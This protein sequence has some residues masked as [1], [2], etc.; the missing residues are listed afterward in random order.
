MR[1]IQTINHMLVVIAL[2]MAAVL[3]AAVAY[4]PARAQTTEESPTA[5]LLDNVAL[6][7]GRICASE[8]GLSRITPGCAAIYEVYHN[9]SQ[10]RQIP[11]LRQARE[12][13]RQSFNRLRTDARRW[14]AFLDPTGAEPQGWPQ[15]AWRRVMVPQEDGTRR[16]MMQQ[17]R[18]AAWSDETRRD[19]FRRRW[20]RL[21]EHSQQIARGEVRHEC[22]LNGH[23]QSPHRW[24]C[25]PDNF[26]EGSCRDHERAERAGW[27]HL[28]CG[29][30]T[31]NW[32]YCDPRI[33]RDCRRP[34]PLPEVAEAET[35]E[36]LGG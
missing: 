19:D 13:S 24:G 8:E 11:W 20:L 36:A 7:L 26:T 22:R 31:R 30:G 10:R 23:R 34:E 33:D 5:V 9:A 12:G 15:H 35:E 14:I 4:A 32:F 17:V 16:E 21:Y 6:A 28:D 25:P 3:F 1:T 2:A 27:V 29:E 18:H